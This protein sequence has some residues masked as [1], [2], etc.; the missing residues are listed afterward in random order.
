MPCKE[1]IL[2]L[3]TPDPVVEALGV[4]NT[5]VFDGTPSSP[6]TTR[7]FNTDV[8]GVQMLLSEIDPESEVR[9]LG[10]GATARSSIFALARQGFAR[11]Q[12]QARDHVKSTQVS[13]DAKTWGIE[14]VPPESTV[15]LLISTIPSSTALE[16]V[17][18]VSPQVIVDVLYHPWPTQL[19][20][21]GQECGARVFSGLDLLAAQA[22][23]QVKFM[24]GN[25]I[26]FSVLR[27]AAEQ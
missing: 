14:V 2:A 15:D 11:V 6:Q 4:G 13:E 25:D 20:Q 18:G 16:W 23:G 7:I 12:V 10:N 9:V 17:Q 26:P 1:A 5:V 19:A 3:G 21:F 24:T 22:V 8:T 27:D